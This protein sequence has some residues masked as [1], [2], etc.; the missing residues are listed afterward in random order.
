VVALGGWGTLV[1]RGKRKKK[2]FSR[3]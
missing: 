3:L 2:N 1:D